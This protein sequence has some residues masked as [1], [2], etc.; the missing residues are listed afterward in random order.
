MRTVLRDAVRPIKMRDRTHYLI[1]SLIPGRRKVTLFMK[2]RIEKRSESRMKYFKPELYVRYN[3]RNDAEADHAD[4]EWEKAIHA[5]REHLTKISK[6]LN[7]R[8]KDLAENICLHDAHLIS[9]QG[10]DS[11]LPLL[12]HIR[13][14]VIS[15]RSKEKMIVLV[16][17]LWREAGVSTAQNKWPFSKLCTLWLYDE[18]DFEQDS[19]FLFWHRIL[20]SNGKVIS[21][22]FFDVFVHSFS[23][24]NHDAA[25]TSR[26]SAESAPTPGPSKRRIVL[27]KDRHKYG[28]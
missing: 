7:D 14:W 12:P 18:V 21:I 6:K 3:S 27:P 24:G 9:S 1:I 28:L 25:I 23:D 13:T 11:D 22:P 26:K 4:R 20:L 19:S 15:L 5:Y 2:P 10:F 16:Y 8:V 17:L